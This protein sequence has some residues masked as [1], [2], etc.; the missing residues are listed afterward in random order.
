MNRYWIFCERL[1]HHGWFQLHWG[2]NDTENSR[3]LPSSNPSAECCLLRQCWCWGSGNA[4]HSRYE[5]YPGISPIIAGFP[6]PIHESISKLLCI[7]WSLPESGPYLDRRG[8]L[9]RRNHRRLCQILAANPCHAVG[10]RCHHPG[11][12]WVRPNYEEVPNE[13]SRCLRGRRHVG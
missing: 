5:S 1:Y 3:G 2:K 13:S 6:S 4:D 7:G 9:L 8:N 12:G 11:Y 10:D